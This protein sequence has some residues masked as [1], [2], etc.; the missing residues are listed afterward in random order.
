MPSSDEQTA[1]RERELVSPADPCVLQTTVR[2][3]REVIG[4]TV[5]LCDRIGELPQQLLEQ[6]HRLG[7]LGP[8]LPAEHGGPELDYPTSA[9][10]ARLLGYRCT[11]I[12]AALACNDLAITALV[13]AGSRTL[14]DQY[15]GLLGQEPHLASFCVTEPSGGTDVAS[16]RTKVV[17]DGHGWVLSGQKAWITHAQRA[18]FYIVFATSDHGGS[19]RGI[20]AFLISRE[21]AGVLPAPAEEK[22]GQRACQTGGISFDAVRIAPQAVLAP[23]GHG[24][25]LAMAVFDRTRPIVA[26]SAVGLIERCLDESLNHARNHQVFG[27]ALGEQGQIQGMLAD[28]AVRAETARLLVQHAT[29]KMRRGLI[30]A[31]SSSMA[32]LHASR[33]AVEAALDAVQIHGALGIAA[34]G[35]TEKLL[36]DAKMFEIYEGTTEIHRQLIARGLLKDGRSPH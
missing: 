17:R 33:S 9:E 24:F 22:L 32:K 2:F 13:L 19:H 11:G 3:A 34:R 6:A 30:D 26:A 35:P 10:V 1:A 27:K 36:R 12:Q 7:L 14:Q 5:E 4:P 20:G 31:R 18:A 23:P 15:L 28:M 21:Q 25:A 29:A 16:L 8:R